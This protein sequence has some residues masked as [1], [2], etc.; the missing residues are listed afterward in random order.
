M[1][2][3]TLKEA[4]GRR[5]RRWYIFVVVVV[6]EEA[7][8]AE[9]RRRRGG[10]GGGERARRRAGN[11][12][13]RRP[14]ALRTWSRMVESEMTALAC[15]FLTRRVVQ[16]SGEIDPR[17]RQAHHILHRRRAEKIVVQSVEPAPC[18]V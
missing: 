6:V 8:R 3:R 7:E 12:T 11:A 4:A 2:G 14:R 18:T 17:I 5:R 16:T 15:Y 10:G 13:Q 1:E 9:R